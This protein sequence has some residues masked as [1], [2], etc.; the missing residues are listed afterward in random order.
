VQDA[1]IVIV[2][3]NYAYKDQARPGETPPW[4][5]NPYYDLKAF[6]WWLSV[7]ESYDDAVLFWNIG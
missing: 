3:E 5:C 6:R 2:D 4:P 7:Q 1:R